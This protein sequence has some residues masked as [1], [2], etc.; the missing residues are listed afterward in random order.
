MSLVLT[1][2]DAIAQAAEELAQRCGETPERILLNALW[3]HFP[4]IPLELQAEFDALEQASDEDFARLEQQ[5][6]GEGHAAG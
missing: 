6:E 5:M 1:V 3:A 2:P 4:P